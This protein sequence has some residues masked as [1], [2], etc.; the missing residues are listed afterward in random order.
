MN[1][2]VNRFILISFVLFSVSQVSEA[3]NGKSAKIQEI[4]TN[5]SDIGTD[6]MNLKKEFVLPETSQVRVVESKPSNLELT[7]DEK[8]QPQPKVKNQLMAMP[9]DF[10][11][12]RLVL[13]EIRKELPQLKKEI[14]DFGG[15]RLT[16]QNDT[17]EDSILGIND[18]QR[19]NTE[20]SKS[21]EKDIPNVDIKSV[22]LNEISDRKKKYE[23]IRNS[24]LSIRN[25]IQPVREEI[26]NFT[27]PNPSNVDTRVNNKSP[28]LFP[29]QEK[30]TAYSKSIE[31]I[32]GF[33]IL[34]GIVS[35]YAGGIKW[36]SALGED[37][38]LDES[39]GLGISGRVGHRWHRFFTEIQ[40]NLIKN[41]I[42]KIELGNLPVRSSGDLDLLG[43]NLNFG[44]NF[45]LSDAL[46]LSL[47][48]GIGGVSQDLD[49]KVSNLSIDEQ[50]FVFTPQAF[51]GLDYFPS[52]SFFMNLRYRY[53]MV[54]KM[55]TFTRRNLHLLETSFGWML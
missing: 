1:H 34:P 5:L 49:L 42:Q 28:V 46:G 31:S 8:K 55:K 30:N 9:S 51:V 54:G 24:L 39:F 13:E 53:A 29:K 10:S 17:T 18:Q 15:S 37:Y 14:Q 20:V 27:S 22:N 7:I 16:V 26:S 50:E 6:L 35:Q 2:P 32:K 19:F 40:F 12:I 21:T 48:V 23:Q 11:E 44:S 36:K 33:Y 41:D 45:P 52:E 43:L 4:R 47:G 25:Q 3:I 38:S